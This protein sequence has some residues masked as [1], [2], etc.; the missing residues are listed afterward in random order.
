MDQQKADKSSKNTDIKSREKPSKKKFII[1]NSDENSEMITL[2]QDYEY[3]IKKSEWQLC[4]RNIDRDLKG[5]REAI[6]GIL[7]TFHP[8]TELLDL[9][10]AGQGH[11]NE[12]YDNTPV[13]E[14]LKKAIQSKKPNI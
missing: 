7:K 9:S 8:D 4:A 6:R 11:P 3:E 1:V 13:E 14:D 12:D 10:A 2:W 5:A